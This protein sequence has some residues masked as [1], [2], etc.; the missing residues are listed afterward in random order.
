[1]SDPRTKAL[2]EAEAALRSKAGE[3]SDM[4]EEEM[5][6]DLEEKAQIWHE[7]ANVVASLTRR[8]VQ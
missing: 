2:Q 3:L 5:R 8:G 6:R 4:A 7:A 1:M